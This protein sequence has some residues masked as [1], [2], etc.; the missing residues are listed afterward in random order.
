MRLSSCHSLVVVTLCCQSFGKQYVHVVLKH[1]SKF[2]K[3]NTVDRSF[4]VGNYIKILE[5]V[6]TKINS[7]SGT[8]SDVNNVNKKKKQ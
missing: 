2:A 8:L 5:Q 4:F 1:S 7:I 6:P 3:I